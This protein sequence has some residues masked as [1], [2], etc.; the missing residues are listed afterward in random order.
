MDKR[1]KIAMTIVSVTVAVVLAVILVQNGLVYLEEY[2]HRYEYDKLTKSS[3]KSGKTT[4]TFLDGGTLK[5]Q[6]KGQMQNYIP[7][8][9]Q[10]IFPPNPWDHILWIYK[11]WSVTALVIEEG[12]SHIGSYAFSDFPTAMGPIV[13]PGSVRS[14][15]EGAFLGSNLTYIDVAE[16]NPNY[17]SIDGVLFS[18]DKTRL[19]QYPANKK[20]TEYTIPYDVTFIE[21]LAFLNC[22]NLV[23]ITIHSR[24]TSVGKRTFGG[25]QNLTS[26][27]IHNPVPPQIRNGT[28]D[29]YGGYSRSDSVHLFVPANSTNAY[30]DAWPEFNYIDTITATYD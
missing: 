28:F 2:V 18:K 15:G 21:E 1:N 27:I 26:I 16:D 20:N 10:G 23:S 4:I 24:V 11:R 25:C 3:W 9:E 12:V 17:S 30:R 7:Y 8:D 5:V 14:I 29:Y 13:I 19:I 22:E 6:G